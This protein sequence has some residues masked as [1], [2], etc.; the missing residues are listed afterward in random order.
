MSPLYCYIVN[1]IV[2][3]GDIQPSTLAK[4]NVIITFFDIHDLPGKKVK[5]QFSIL[6]LIGVLLVTVNHNSAV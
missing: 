6:V 4:S 5:F 1:A 3:Y 2:I